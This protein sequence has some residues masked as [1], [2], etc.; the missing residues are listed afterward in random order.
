MIEKPNGGTRLLGIP[1][2]G[3][4]V[5]QQSIKTELQWKFDPYFSENSYGFRPGRSALQAIERT[6]EYVKEGKKWVVEIDLKGFFE[7]STMTG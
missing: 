3:D 1:T 4:R 7:K 5:V 6:N 2:I